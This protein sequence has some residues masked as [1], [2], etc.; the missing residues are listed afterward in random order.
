MV[1]LILIT[2][3]EKLK[4]DSEIIENAVRRWGGLGPLDYAYRYRSES[5]RNVGPGTSVMKAIG[6]PFPQDILDMV[7]YRK[8]LE[9]CL[10]LTYLTMELMII[11]LVKALKRK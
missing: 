3:R 5:D 6:G 11:Y 4:P 1:R 2:K 8:V 10:L 9:K 7:L